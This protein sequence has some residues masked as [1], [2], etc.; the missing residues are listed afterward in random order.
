[1]KNLDLIKKEFL[2]IYNFLRNFTQEDILQGNNKEICFYF[3]RLNNLAAMDIYDYEA[4]NIRCDPEFQHII[5]HISELKRVNGLRMEI[6]NARD[7]IKASLPW[8]ILNK[9][10]YVPNYLE[11]ARMEYHGGNLTIGDR[12]VF[13]GSGPLPLSLIFL[14]TQYGIKSIGIE[15]TSEYAELSQEIINVLKLKEHI[16]IIQGNHFSLP[17]EQDCQLIMIGADALPKHEIFN[18]LT[19]VLPEKTRLSYRIYEKGLRCLLDIQSFFE[20]PPEF[21]EYRRIRPNPPVNNTSVFVI[22]K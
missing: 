18:H 17:L 7:I 4:E 13:L 16:C 14:Y 10:V 20:L 15:Q 8:D 9:F 6:E 2:D 22:K 1:M 11:L 21:K 12:V 19:K 5:K 3:N